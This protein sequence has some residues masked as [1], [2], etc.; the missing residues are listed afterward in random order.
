MKIHGNVKVKGMCVSFF[1][2]YATECLSNKILHKTCR[3]FQKLIGNEKSVHRL[4]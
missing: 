3:N 2:V 4:K 1:L